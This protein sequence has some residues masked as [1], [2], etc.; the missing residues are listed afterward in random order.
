MGEAFRDGALSELV[1]ETHVR[2][3]ELEHSSLD[4]LIERRPIRPRHLE[5]HVSLA[6]RPDNRR[7]SHDCLGVFGEPPDTRKDRVPHRRKN[8]ASHA[9]QNLRDEKGVSCG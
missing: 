3:I 4:A 8:V 5:Q 2:T 7:G 9:G 6:S 1:P